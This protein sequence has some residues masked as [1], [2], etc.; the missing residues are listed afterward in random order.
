MRVKIL[1]MTMAVIVH[2]YDDPSCVFAI[3]FAL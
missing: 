2:I 3:G 1:I